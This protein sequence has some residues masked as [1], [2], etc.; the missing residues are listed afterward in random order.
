MRFFQYEPSFPLHRTA[1]TTV[2]LF[3]VFSSS[4]PFFQLTDPSFFVTCEISVPQ[5]SPFPFSLLNPSLF[6]RVLS[7]PFVLDFSLLGPKCDLK[8]F[9]FP[10]FSLRLLRV[11]PA[12]FVWAVF[13]RGWL[14][15]RFSPPRWASSLFFPPKGAIGRTGRSCLP[16]R[17]E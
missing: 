14:V 11:P 12:F 4:T 17:S 5:P 15:E 16:P 1:R 13:E 3:S 8:I 7:A 6:P 10:R 2:S 9:L